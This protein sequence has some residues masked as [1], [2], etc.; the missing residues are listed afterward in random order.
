MDKILA[1]IKQRIIE[2][3]KDGGVVKESFYEKA[4]ISPSNFKGTGLNS[5]IGGDKIAK[6]LSIFPEL[7]PDWLITGKGQK[8]K[9]LYE[10]DLP[11][12]KVDAVRINLKSKLKQKQQDVPLISLEAAAGFGNN[13]FLIKEEDIQDRYII[14][15][16]NDIDFMIRVKGSSMY[17][18]YS[19][20][21]VVA[22]RIIKELKFIQWNKSYVIATKQ[23]GILCKRLLQSK[24]RNNIMAVS[25]NKDYPPFDIPKDEITGY[26]LII[27]VIRLE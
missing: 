24:I 9:S 22:C 4:G 7:N 5:E 25:D 23:Q 14:P 1:P 8:R 18:K 20:G 17:P 16:F 10:D 3:L 15:D 6:I 27:G 19:S 2:F 26:A 21:D 12:S 13:N 11:N